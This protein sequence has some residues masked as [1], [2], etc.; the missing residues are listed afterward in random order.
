MRALLLVAALAAACYPNPDQI[1]RQS[2]VPMPGAGGDGGSGGT[3]PGTGGTGGG[4]PPDA[5]AAERPPS[6][7]RCAD[8]AARFCA[9]YTAC[10]APQAALAFGSEPQCRER[11]QLECDLLELPGVTWPTQQC[12][13][14]FAAHSCDELLRNADPAPCRQ[15]GALA[16]GAEC[17]SSFQCQ[18]RRC[19]QFVGARC[20]TCVERGGPGAPC[21]SSVACQDDLVCGDRRVCVAPRALGAACD[22]DGPCQVP[23]LCKQGKCA[24]RGGEGAPCATSDDCDIVAGI[25]CNA[26]LGKCVRYTVG[27][28]CRTRPDGT[29]ELCAGRGTCDQAT[30]TCVPAAAD[31]A[32]CSDELGPRC[33]SPATCKNQR[34][35]LP[36]PV[37]CPT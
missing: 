27:G 7:R 3:P 32:P 34:C 4:S 30:L 19:S 35:T 20:F 29:F 14:A 16:A 5:A 8:Y 11:V 36:A 37:A 6:Q 25:G 9:R 31:G 12:A 33:R 10:S 15:G 24:A 26:A 21:G 2:D 23:L 18:T 17:A 22:A 28:T 13:D 1:R